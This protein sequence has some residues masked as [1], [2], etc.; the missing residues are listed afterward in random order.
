VKPEKASLVSAAFGDGCSGAVSI[1][2]EGRQPSQSGRDDAKTHAKGPGPENAA[3]LP[4]D[5]L[6]HPQ[7]DG[8]RK[9]MAAIRCNGSREV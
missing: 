2:R 8:S 9:V 1:L 4:D 6:A 3:L 7:G 5:P